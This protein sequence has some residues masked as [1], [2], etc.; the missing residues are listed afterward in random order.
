MGI[1]VPNKRVLPVIG[2]LRVLL[3]TEIT[4]PDVTTVDI[5]LRLYVS[6][7][8]H[9]SMQQITFSY[10]HIIYKLVNLRII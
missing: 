8:L 6:S 4:K 7:F 3:S 9:F 5:F 1:L 10:L 2:H